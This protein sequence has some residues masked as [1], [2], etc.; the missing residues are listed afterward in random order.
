MRH[1]D[2]ETPPPAGHRLT[3]RSLL[4]GGAGLALTVF[5]G[6][7]LAPEAF[8]E[9]IAGAAEAAPSAPVIVSVFLS[10][11]VDGLALLP[12]VTDP[13]Y[14]PSLRPSLWVDLPRRCR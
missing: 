3:R 8:A 11:G 6:R 12:P 4:L 14:V 10:G 13:R 2:H 9:G 7:V 1:C 5:G